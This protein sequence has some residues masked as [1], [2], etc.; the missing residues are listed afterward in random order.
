MTRGEP[1]SH[2]PATHEQG[3]RLQKVL[4]HAGV[5]SRR[6]CEDLITAG[7]VE[8]NG[9]IVTTLGTRINPQTAQVKVDGMTV[10][11]NTNLLTLALYKPYGV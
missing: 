3:E 4:A 6:A 9:Q 5:A 8:V 7:R 2:E 11:L 10:V 1:V